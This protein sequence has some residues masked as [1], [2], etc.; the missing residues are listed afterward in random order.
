CG[1]P[2]PQVE[3]LLGPSAVYRSEH[4]DVRIHQRVVTS[5]LAVAGRSG[6]YCHQRE[7]VEPSPQG[8]DEHNGF[9]LWKVSAD[10][11]GL[12]VDIERR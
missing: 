8:G 9:E 2:I 10:L 4:G 3:D 11:T 5:S 1:G 12:T 7:R 6:G